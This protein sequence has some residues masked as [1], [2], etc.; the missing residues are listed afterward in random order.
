MASKKAISKTDGQR[1]HYQ[2]PGPD[3]A[4][5]RTRMS[6]SAQHSTK[7]YNYRQDSSDDAYQGLY[8]S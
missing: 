4:E 1:L 3:N 2:I 8:V 7:I 5:A 6:T